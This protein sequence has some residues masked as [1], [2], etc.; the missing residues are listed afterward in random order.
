MTFS[1]QED[2]LALHRLIAQADAWSNPRAED[3][4]EDGYEDDSPLA[5]E[6]PLETLLRW[7]GKLRFPDLDSPEIPP[8]GRSPGRGLRPPQ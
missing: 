6:H 4:S 1:D 5:D 2:D 8:Q 7:W 3:G